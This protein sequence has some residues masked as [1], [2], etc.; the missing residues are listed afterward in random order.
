MGS[1]DLFKKRR[2]ARKQRRY[3][4]KR[5]RANSFLIVTEGECTEPL[6]FKGMQRLIEEKIGGS[7]EVVEVPVID[8]QGKGCATRSMIKAT[9]QIV[10]NA[11][12]FYQ[13]IWVV[14]DRDDFDDL[15]QAVQEGV[16]RGYRIAWSNQSFEYW[17]YLHFHYSDAALHREEWKRKLDEI[18]ER[19]Q[20]GDGTYRKNY[21]DIYQ[22]VDSFDGVSTAIKHARSRMAEYEERSCRPSS[23]DPGTTVYLLVE[24]LKKYLDE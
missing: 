12:I 17:L 21:E 3:E 7:V 15:D 19:Y 14:F 23:Y 22:L 11:K 6:Y 8:I 13:N 16:E 24:Q 10:K 1:D 18:F 2:A 20:L 9:D 4:Y 5:P